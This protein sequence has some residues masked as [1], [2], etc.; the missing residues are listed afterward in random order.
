MEETDEVVD[1]GILKL[2][3]ILVL[4]FLGEVCFWMVSKS[5]KQFEVFLTIEKRQ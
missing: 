1:A 4:G 5:L 3:L 2:E